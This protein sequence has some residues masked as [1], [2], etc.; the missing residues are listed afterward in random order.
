MR[1]PPQV[2]SSSAGQGSPLGASGRDQQ[3]PR[4]QFSMARSGRE[5]SVPRLGEVEGPRS[6]GPH[7][8]LRV[9]TGAQGPGPGRCSPGFPR[10]WLRGPGAS[11]R[12]AGHPTPSRGSGSAVGLGGRQACP[13]LRSPR[14]LW[15]HGALLAPGA[16]RR[17][18]PAPWRA[19]S[20][21]GTEPS[22]RPVPQQPPSSLSWLCP[23]PSRVKIP[24]VG[25][26]DSPV[27]QISSL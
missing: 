25:G 23:F 4:S 1:W 18:A 17:V 14:V 21:L 24:K 16:C 15:G 3:G 10:A 13:W 8:G 11:L 5:P 9:T 12:A 22:L 6:T 20:P 7:L 27:S 2:M 26:Q 19:V